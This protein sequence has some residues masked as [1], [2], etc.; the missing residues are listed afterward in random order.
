MTLV[1]PLRIDFWHTAGLDPWSWC[2][3]MGMSGHVSTAASTRWRR[4]ASPA[5]VRAPAD[6]CRMTGLSTCA[7]ASMMPW[8]CSMLFTLNA[9]RP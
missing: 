9:G 4:N 5:Y 6:P 3:A 7:A 1:K 8:I 2:M